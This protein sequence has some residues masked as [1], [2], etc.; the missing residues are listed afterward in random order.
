MTQELLS[1]LSDY[2]FALIFGDQRHIEILAAFLKSILNLPEDEYDHLVIVNPFLKRLW[3][4]DKLGIV[5]VRVHTRS[6]KVIH[7][8]VQA[9]PFSWMRN[10][11]VF[12]IAK[13]LWEQIRGGDGYDR[14]HQV[15]SI[16]ICD[17]VLLPEEKDYLNEYG[18]RNR[19]SGKAFTDLVKVITLELPKLPET[20]DAQ[21]VWAWAR[22]LRSKTREEL[23]AAAALAKGNRGLEMA[24]A[25]YKKLTWSEQ[26]RMIADEKEKARRD[27]AAML[28]YARM[29][30]E[31]KGRMEGEAKGRMEGEAKGRMKLAALIHS[32]KTLDEAMNILQSEA[33]DSSGGV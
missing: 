25:E 2:A 24:V 5:D 31:A 9:N 3:K 33:A 18:L 4:K 8:E 32:G 30:G 23:E 6:G 26:R 14:I 22:F 17:Y 1:P 11:I 13:L 21:K 10:R 19:G 7:V 20:P 15:I 12:Y 16:V 29:E 27:K 28:H